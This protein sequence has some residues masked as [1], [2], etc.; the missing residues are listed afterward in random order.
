MVAAGDE[1][2]I[3]GAT[4][5]QRA[6]LLDV[7]RVVQHH[8]HPAP[9]QRRPVLGD[10]RFVGQGAQPRRRDAERRQEVAGHPERVE[11]LG[12]RVEAA[13]V[14]VE[15]AV[16]VATDD[17]VRPPQR[18]RRLADATDAVDRGD[19]HGHPRPRLGHLGQPGE[20][21]LAPD[22]VRGRGGELT[23]HDDLGGHLAAEHLL[24]CLA[25]PPAGIDPELVRQ[26]RADLLVGRERPRLLTRAVQREHQLGPERLAQRVPPHQRPQLRHQHVGGAGEVL[27][28][29]PLQ[30]D[31]L[32]LQQRRH[33]LVV[34]RVRRHVAEHRAAPQLQCRAVL[35]PRGERAEPGEVELSGFDL[36]RVAARRRADA[37]GRA[38]RLPEPHHHGLQGLVRAVR[39]GRLTVPDA[40]D[41]F[42]D[43]DEL[44]GAQQQR[45][46]Q[47]A[48]SPGGNGDG[49]AVEQ[50][51]ERPQHAVLDDH[52]GTPHSR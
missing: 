26:P 12:A 43:R 47:H 48:A 4:G 8:Q 22:E 31:H 18:E 21:V 30:R 39:R 38:E 15:L 7:P 16:R 45:G 32:L 49:L 33:V 34:Q 35:T 42:V 10:H 11:R 52:P 20:L 36:G 14:H 41:Q 37:V 24:V 29:P 23:R 28:D 17:L 50:H 1:H 44:V 9:R 5:Q 13:Q 3:A 40:F 27:V 51:F 25:Q 46:Q 2:Q 19:E 6:H